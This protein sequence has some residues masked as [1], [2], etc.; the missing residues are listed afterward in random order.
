MAQLIKTNGEIV[1]YND[2]SL[3]AMQ[4][5]VGGYIQLVPAQFSDDIFVCDEEGKLKQKKKNYTA[6]NLAYSKGA[7]YGGDFLVGDVIMAK[8]NDIP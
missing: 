1:D 5:A 8:H 2:F 7:L 3:E 6:T 4:K